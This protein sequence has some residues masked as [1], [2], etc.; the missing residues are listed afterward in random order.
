[1]SVIISLI[2]LLLIIFYF[3]SKWVLKRFNLGNNKNRKYVAIIPAILLG[4]ITYIGFIIIW[5]LYTSYYPHENFSK[6]KWDTNIEERYTMSEDIIKSN[7]LIGKTKDEIII[8]LGDDYYEYNSHHIGYYLGFVPQVM[9][10]DP[11]ILDI[12]FKDDKVI[13]VSQHES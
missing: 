7:I 10:I 6:D 8:L 5:I 2:I 3:L 1:M 13:K 4:L 11:D 12:Y 9:G